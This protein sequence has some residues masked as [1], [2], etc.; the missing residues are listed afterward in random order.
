MFNI[1]LKIK[2]LLTITMLDSVKFEEL[3]D[4]LSLEGGVGIVSN[5]KGLEYD[6]TVL[7]STPI[8]IGKQTKALQEIHIFLSNIGTQ[9]EP[10]D[11]EL[12]DRYNNVIN[13]FN[14][15]MG[16]NKEMKNP[17]LALNFKNVGYL[18]VMQSSLY[19]LSDDKDL[20]VQTTHQLANLFALSG[21]NV[22]REKIEASVYGINGI[23]QT[24]E[25][26][27][28]YSGYFEFHIRVKAQA[29]GDEVPLSSSELKTLNDI[30]KLYSSQFNTPVPISYNKAFDK[31]GSYQR[32]LNVRFDK[33]G[34]VNALKNVKS[35][36]D[37]IN[38][39][40]SLK[41]VKLIAEYVWYD[42]FRELD[43]GWIDF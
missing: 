28:K 1:S 25:E 20:I 41:F 3:V 8:M 21:F 35:I 39:S 30:S 33:T 9:H 19:V 12:L 11:Q 29:E 6:K 38:S 34:A 43:S 37:T 26:A 23:P 10:I 17:L 27:Q 13:E 42:T 40:Q 31:D 22:I 4:K 24:D 16:F 15:T 5:W 7:E 36:I 18:T 14:K 2:T 32:Y